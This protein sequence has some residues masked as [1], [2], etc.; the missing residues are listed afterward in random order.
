MRRIEAAR[1]QTAQ[2]D[3]YWL[4]RELAEILGYKQWRNFENVISRARVAIEA[5][6][7]SSS[8]HVAETS[9]MV[10]VG[11]GGKRRVVEYFLSRAACYLIAMNGEPTKPEVAGA[12]AYFT[13]Q[14]R[15]AELLDAEM[16]DRD[17]LHKREKASAALKRVSDIAKDVGVTRYDYFHGAKYRGMYEMSAKELGRHKGLREGENLLDRAGHLE[18]SAHAF[19]ADLAAEKILK[20]GISGEQAAIS[21]NREVAGRV[22]KLVISEAGR[23]PEDLELEPEPIQVVKKRL[24]TPRKIK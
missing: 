16:K 13:V 18:L 6:G 3:D 14:T 24:R 10:G 17:R 21:A 4:A 11:D 19:Q 22:R 1:R 12:Q 7:G 15:R 20:D 2:G 5:T 9:K 23:A 8:H